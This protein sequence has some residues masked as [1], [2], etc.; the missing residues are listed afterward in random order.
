MWNWAHQKSPAPIMRLHQRGEIVRV[1]REGRVSKNPT[2]KRIDPKGMKERLWT[3]VE[4]LRS[5]GAVITHPQ[6]NQGG[7]AGSRREQYQA[8]KERAAKERRF[9]TRKGASGA[10]QSLKGSPK[11]RPS[12]APGSWMGGWTSRP[13]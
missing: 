6:R 2:K 3:F 10:L 12:K 11:S 4:Q 8:K 9:T 5:Q 7:S 13:K 1:V